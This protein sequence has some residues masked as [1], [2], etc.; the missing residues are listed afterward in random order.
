MSAFYEVYG[1][2]RVRKCPEAE[3]I[4]ARLLDYTAGEIEVDVNECDPEV[5]AVA[6]EGCG[7][8]VAGSVLDYDAFVQSLGPYTVEPAVLV[9]TSENEEGEL[10]VTSS[11]AQ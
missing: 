11:E 9:T 2:I 5:L 1:T 10:I 8:F 7:F 3:A 4:I 6:F